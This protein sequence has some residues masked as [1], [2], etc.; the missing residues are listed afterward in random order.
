MGVRET[1]ISNEIMITVAKHGCILFK[2]VRGMFLTLDGKRKVRAGLSIQGSHDLIGYKR[3][4]ITPDMVGKTVA[5]FTSMEVKV[6]GGLVSTPQWT[7]RDT[8]RLHG[9]IAGIVHSPDEA[10]SLLQSPCPYTDS[11]P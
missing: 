10:I 11:A 4:T 1:S 7:F 9:G 3:I 8:V 2:N 6:P 5:I